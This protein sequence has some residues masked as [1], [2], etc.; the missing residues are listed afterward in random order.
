MRDALR[1]LYDPVYLQTHPL[2]RLA[3]SAAPGGPEATAGA[4]LRRCLLET[5]EALQPPQSGRGLEEGRQAGARR[6]LR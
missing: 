6:G 3:L 4:A 2:T 1:H 5:I